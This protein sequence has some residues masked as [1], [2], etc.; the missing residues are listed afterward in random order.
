MTAA[1]VLEAALGQ[2]GCCSGAALVLMEG[3]AAFAG[4]NPCYPLSLPSL[5]SSEIS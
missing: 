3:S 2:Q 4:V 1:L 5:L